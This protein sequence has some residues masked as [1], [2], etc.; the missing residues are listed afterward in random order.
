MSEQTVTHSQ[1]GQW[2]NDAVYKTDKSQRSDYSYSDRLGG[3]FLAKV[4]REGW[5]LVPIEPDPQPRP[6]ERGTQPRQQSRQDR[7]GAERGPGITG[8]QHVR[9]QVLLGL[10]VEGQEPGHRQITPRVVVT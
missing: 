1:V 4:A 10:L 7:D 9:E 2:I 8:A 3:E 6:R 5:R